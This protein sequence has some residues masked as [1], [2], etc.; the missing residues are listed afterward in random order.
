MFFSEFIASTLLMFL[1]YAIKVSII[2]KPAL[3]EDV[4]HPFVG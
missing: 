1:I 3:I 2:V 4:A